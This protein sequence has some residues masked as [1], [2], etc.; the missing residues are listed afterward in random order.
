MIVAEKLFKTYGATVAVNDVSFNVG[1][2][3]ILGFLG[4]NGAGKSTTLKILTCYICADSGSVTVDGHDVLEDSVEVRR[5]IGYLPETTPLYADMQ[6]Q[7]YL[8]FVGRARQLSSAQARDAIDRV[9]EQVQITR[10]LKKNIGHLSK[11]YK[12]RVGLAQALIH[13]PAILILDEPTSGLDPH[14]II[15]IRELLRELGKSKVI[16]F[17]SHILQE[18]SAICTR[19]MVINDGRLVANGRPDELERQLAGRAVVRAVVHGPENEAREKLEALDGV[20]SVE[21]LGTHGSGISFRL[22]GGEGAE[23]GEQVFDAVRD[24]GWKLSALE[25]ESRSLEDVYL[26]LTQKKAQAS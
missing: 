4:P 9:V 11:G 22:R 21:V 17:S 25:R 5:R 18:I 26:Q 15:E 6:V 24:G 20:E 1:E 14:Q 7:E 16:L 3:E 10:M 19:V 12:Q 8:Q 23:L 13:D 2:G